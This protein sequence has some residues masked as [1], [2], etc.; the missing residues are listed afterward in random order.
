MQK[1]QNAAMISGE[2]LV[3]AR[4]VPVMTAVTPA[5][6][7]PPSQ[8]PVVSTAVITSA[9]VAITPA[10]D[11]IRFVDPNLARRIIDI[12][13]ILTGVTRDKLTVPVAAA[14]DFADDA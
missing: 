7:A 11:Q 4:P 14:A 8:T 13:P 1:F 6:A 12:Q 5:P 3:V 9:K 2:S 10:V